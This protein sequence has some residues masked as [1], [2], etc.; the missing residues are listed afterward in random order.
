MLFDWHG[1]P[2]TLNFLTDITD[3]RAMD[4]TIRDLTF[5]D[6]LT[7]LP[8]RRLL[9][10]HLNL[11]I[12]NNQRSGRLSAVVFLDLDNFKPLNDQYGHNVGDLLLIEVSERLRQQIREIDSVARLGGDEFVVLLN[13]LDT[14]SGAAA[15]QACQLAQQ[16]ILTLSQPYELTMTHNG[17]TQ[18]VSHCCT[19]S[20]GVALFGGHSVDA[21]SILDQADSAMY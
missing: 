11:A 20:A 17:Q 1:R 12:A 9:L 16:L 19:A 8:N 7:K 5:N 14:D 4:E 6:T 13:K 3:R 2:A 15:K 10:D 18:P 21:E